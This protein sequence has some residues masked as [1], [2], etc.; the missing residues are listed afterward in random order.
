METWPLCHLVPA[1]YSSAFSVWVDGCRQCALVQLHWWV[2]DHVPA[3]LFLGHP[4]QTWRTLIYLCFCV[5]LCV[6]V[7][8]Q[9][10]LVGSWAS[11]SLAVRGAACG[12]A[13][14]RWPDRD[15]PPTIWSAPHCPPH[16]AGRTGGWREDAPLLTALTN[17]AEMDRREEKEREW[18]K[19]V[20]CNQWV[21][22][23]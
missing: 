13:W 11:A 16:W 17:A 7:Y 23:K 21:M 22:L 1:K 19:V 15:M 10:V 18:L 2:A 6:C 12:N 9:K 20:G 4:G 5:Q 8:Q 3:N 14:P